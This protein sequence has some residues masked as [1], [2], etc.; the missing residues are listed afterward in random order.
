MFCPGVSCWP[1]L[2]D[3]WSSGLRSLVTELTTDFLSEVIHSISSGGGEDEGGLSRF[4]DI[5]LGLSGPEVT[6][7]L[8][9]LRLCINY[10]VKVMQ[11]LQV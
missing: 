2:E 10:N 11:K 6:I 3:I 4:L 8:C 9:N 7:V 5:F 1:G